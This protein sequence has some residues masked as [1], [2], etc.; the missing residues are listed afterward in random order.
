[1]GRPAHYRGTYQAEAKRIRA[2]ANADPTTRCWRCARTLAEHPNHHNGK[3]PT[4]T[5]GHVNDAQ[6]GGPLAPEAST[7]NYSHGHRAH[8]QP[9]TVTTKRW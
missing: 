7:C 4:W 3:P 5:A 9:P 1:M 6:V 2:L 8:E